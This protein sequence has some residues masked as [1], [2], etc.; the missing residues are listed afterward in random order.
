[1]FIGG[2]AHVYFKFGLLDLYVGFF[3]NIKKR[4]MQGK[5]G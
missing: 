4:G 3:Q 5:N 2:S 1:M